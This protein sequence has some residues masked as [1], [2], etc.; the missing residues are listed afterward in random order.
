[1][2]QQA[3]ELYPNTV[4]PRVLLA[5]QYLLEGKTEQ[6][7]ATLNEVIRAQHSN[8]P[9]VL[10]ILGQAE[11]AS[12]AFEKAKITYQHLVSLQPDSPQ[13]HFQLAKAYAGLNNSDG[14][15]KELYKTLELAPRD[16]NA[17]IALT[18]VWLLEGD[19]DRAKEQLASLKALAPNSSLVHAFEGEIYS[20]SG[21]ADKALAAYQALFAAEPDTRNLLRLTQTQWKMGK[22]EESLKQLE[23]WVREHP[24]DVPARQALASSYIELN[25]PRDAIAQHEQSLKVSE[26]NPIVLNDLAWLLRET[27]PERALQLAKKASSIAPNSVSIMDTVAA[28]LLIQG[29]TEAAQT[30]IGKALEIS[31]DSATVLFRKATLLEATGKTDE[32]IMVL[33]SLLQKNPQFPERAEAE[34]MLK[35]LNGS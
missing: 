18:R 13:A 7:F 12:R 29:D 6:V 4:T 19:L 10:G 35:R 3:I 32:A 33:N 15:K 34:R 16:L 20:K 25:R 11:L 24:D 17:N 21:E 30:I 9:V 27:D 2:L 28:I 26:N 31:P 5:R 1:M 22:R 8:N 14:V 23:G